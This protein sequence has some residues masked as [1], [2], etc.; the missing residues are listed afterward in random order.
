MSTLPNIKKEHLNDFV[1]FLSSIDS[2]FEIGS[3]KD[4][5][6][7]FL[8]ILDIF[9]VGISAVLPSHNTITDTYFQGI[10]RNVKTCTICSKDSF[11]FEPFFPS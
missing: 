6:E 10:Y 7:A 5:H 8:K 9:D 2:F 4:A 11:C 3:Q 1:S